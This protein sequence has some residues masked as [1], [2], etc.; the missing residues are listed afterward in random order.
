MDD[1]EIKTSFQ[2]MAPCAAEKLFE[3]LKIINPD[4]TLVAEED[5][6]FKNQILLPKDGGNTKT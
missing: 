2:H 6:N 5:K 4:G 3:K 1:F